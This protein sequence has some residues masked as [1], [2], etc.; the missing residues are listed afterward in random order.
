MAILKYLRVFDADR[1]SIIKSNDGFIYK[2]HIC[3]ELEML[4]ISLFEFMKDKPARCLSVKE[5]RPVLQQVCAAY[6][7]SP[8]G[9]GRT[10]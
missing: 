2:D 3:L 6:V 4:D 1:F 10:V 8:T 7:K 9:G 5:I